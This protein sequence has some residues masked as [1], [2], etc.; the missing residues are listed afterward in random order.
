VQECQ[1]FSIEVLPVLGKP[2]APIEPSE[3]ALDGPAFGQDHKSLGLIGTLDDFNFQ[4]REHARQSL[5]EFGS[6]IAAIGEQLFQERKH[7]EQVRHDQNAAIA[8]LNIGRMDDGM[9][10]QAQCVYKNM[11]LLTLDFFARIIA[12]RIDAGPPFSALLTL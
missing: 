5:V 10:Q 8:I 1:R 6:L 11:P 4:I 3:G 2:A 12:V 9:K 7:S